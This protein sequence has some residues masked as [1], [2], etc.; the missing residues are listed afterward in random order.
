[1]YLVGT[2]AQKYNMSGC[3]SSISYRVRIAPQ[4]QFTPRLLIFFNFSSCLSSQRKTTSECGKENLKHIFSPAKAVYL[5]AS[6]N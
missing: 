3:T 2:A 4:S 1:M 5:V 6:L